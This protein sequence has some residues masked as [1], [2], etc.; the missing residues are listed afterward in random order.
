MNN[1]RK[2][3]LRIILFFILFIPAYFAAYNIWIMTGDNFSVENT[4]KVE[5]L[6]IE[7]NLL[8][9]YTDR[10]DIKSFIKTLDSA[11]SVSTVIRPLE[12]EKP[13]ILMFYKGEKTFTY[14]MYLSLENTNDCIIKTFDGNLLHMQQT[15]A[16]KILNTPLS[17]ILY[18]NNNLPV[19]K[20]IQGEDSYNIYPR[21]GEW[22]LR[23]PDGNYYISTVPNFIKESNAAK[24]YQNRAFDIRF[25]IEPDILKVEVKEG[26]EIIFSDIYS[27]FTEQFTCDTVKDLE[28]IVTAEWYQKEETDFYGNATYVFDVKY[29]VPAKF[30]ISQIEAVPGEIVAVTAYNMTA[31]DKLNIITDVDLGFEPK[32]VSFGANRVSLIPIS[33]D[34]AGKKINLTVTS[35]VNEPIIY[36]IKINESAESSL[37]KMTANDENV[38][39]HLTAAAQ[40]GR[41]ERYNAIFGAPSGINDKYWTEKFILPGP[42]PDKIWIGYG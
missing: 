3:L 33:R 16:E 19:A 34:L 4:T 38:A 23:K 20:L 13:L 30:D 39:K 22:E 42:N 25:G 29:F 9:E 1:G 40:A 15:D 10:N 36:H 32:F 26:K 6:D 5:I 24:A 35:E 28:Y 7:G 27:N 14:G 37:K 41:L 2:T 12:Y 31:D 17:D 8:A 18:P 21:S 11:T